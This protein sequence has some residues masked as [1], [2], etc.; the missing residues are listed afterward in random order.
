VLCFDTSYGARLYLN[1]LVWERVGRLAETDDLTCR[2]RGRAET[3]AV[4][5]RK[6]R[7]GAIG[8]ND[9]TCLLQ[10][11]QQESQAGAFRW[12]ALSEAVISRLTRVHASLPAALAPRKA[13]G[14]HRACASEH[15]PKQVH[16]NDR[17]LLDCAGHF[18]VRG[19]NII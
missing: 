15:G 4:F 13:D 1:D 19:V 9:L 6:F 11:F 17:R 18:G 16:S 5:H 2:I 8:S 3:V 7:E 14:Q 10:Q 12:L